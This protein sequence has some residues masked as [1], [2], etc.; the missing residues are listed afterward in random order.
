[1]DRIFFRMGKITEQPENPET[2]PENP[3]AGAS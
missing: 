1:M 3:V 2:N